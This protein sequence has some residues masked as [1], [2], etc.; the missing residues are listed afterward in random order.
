MRGT[1]SVRGLLYY[2]NKYYDPAQ[3]AVPGASCSHALVSMIDF[4]LKNT[5][6]PNKPTAVINLLADW[7]KAFNKVNHNIIMRILVAL[8]IPQWLLRLIL[9]YLQ[10][11]KMILRFRNCASSPRDLPGGCPQ[12]TLIGVI[13]YILYINPIGFPGE[14]TLQINDAVKNYWSQ[15]PNLPELLPN[16]KL[17][18]N[19]LNA[20]KYMDDATVQEAV[21]LTDNLATKIDRSG[22]LP[23]WESSGKLL[24][25]TN[26][27]LHSEIKALK[28]ISDEREMVL[29]ADK[30]KVL[31]VNFTNNHQFQSL[32]TIPGAVSPIELTFETKILGYWL[33]SD[34]K[35]G[36]H[37]S[38]IL[39][40]AYGRLWAI[41]RLKS[42]N[43]NNDDILHFFNV[44]IRSVLEYA[45]PVFTSMLTVENTGDIERIQKIAFKVI[46]NENYSSYTQ[47]CDILNSKSLESRRKDLSLTFA[48]K[49]LKSKNHSHFF[50][51]R[52]CMIYKLRKIKAFEEPLCHSERYKSSP[53]P[54][55]TRLLNEYF[56]TK[57]GSY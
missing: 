22:P 10:N 18:P 19:N 52:T 16:N 11:R 27:F 35:P 9:S 33:T 37:V 29:N 39:K 47:A 13:L 28:S 25:N 20:A 24:P 30:T 2:I 31:I 6:N 48:L 44:K 12:G 17:L 56:S 21:D 36:K 45:A 49:S 4:I 3:Y 41:S 55:L 1:P 54:Y 46:L 50:K 38:H 14:I 15:M 26:T 57:I 8:K 53:V 5:D 7:S 34:M 51:Q 40:I 32:L 43:V 42:A 23:W